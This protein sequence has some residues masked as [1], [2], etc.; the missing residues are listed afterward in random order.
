MRRM[1]VQATQVDHVDIGFHAGRDAAPVLEAH[2]ARGVTGEHLDGAGQFDPLGRIGVRGPVRQEICRQRG[3]AD[4]SIVGA[5]VAEAQ[6]H[7]GVLEESL[8]RA[9]EPLANAVGRWAV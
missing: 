7:V 8:T 1:K 6:Q 3:V 4:H 9:F 5:A 2:R